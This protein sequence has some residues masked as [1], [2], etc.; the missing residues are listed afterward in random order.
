MT[1]SII[2]AVKTWQKNLEECVNKC[3]GLDYPQFEIII[4]PDEKIDSPYHNISVIPSGNV[5][6]PEKR[7]LASKSARG[8]ILAFIDD[9]AYP[10]E[11]WLKNAVKNF[12]DSETAAVGGPAITP[13]HD[14][15]RQKASGLIYENI[16]VSGPYRY[17][18]KKLSKR[19]IEDYPS[20]NFLIRK[21]IFEKLGGFDT[22]YWPGEDT[23][24]CL[25]IINK[26]NKKIIYHPEV[27][28]YHHRRPLFL[29]HLRQIKNYALHRG[30]FAKKFPK[31]SF[32]L[33]YF[34]PSI[35]VL[36]IIFGLILSLFSLIFKKLFTL[37]FLIYLG[38]V[39]IF[40]LNRNLRMTF[41]VLPGIIL[42]HLTYGIFFIK[43]FLAKKL[44][45]E[46]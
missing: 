5:S 16:L 7:D 42:S 23:K 4:V 19:F 41:L 30:Y 45:E 3:L 38:I 9:D 8:E 33:S 21:D 37:I 14:S 12:K 1:I 29:S 43:G 31:T 39:F 46:K 32:K 17:R 40:S 27:V 28:V 25:E 2:I 13:P 26:L 10:E 6:P 11:N 18:Y 35:F 44:K 36:T 20:C 24:L 34:L 15:L 22:K